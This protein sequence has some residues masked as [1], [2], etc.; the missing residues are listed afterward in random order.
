MSLGERLSTMDRPVGQSPWGYLNE[1]EERGKTQLMV[2]STIPSAEGLD[3]ESEE[4]LLGAS[5]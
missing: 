4:T 1:G 5:K 3:Y 2:G